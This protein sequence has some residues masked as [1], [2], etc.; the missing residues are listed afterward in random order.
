VT[1]P[2]FVLVASP[3]TGPFAW[4]KVA[5]EL[6]ARGR[7]VA[8]DGVDPGLDAPVVLV[9]HSGAGPRLPMVATRTDGVVGMV[10]VDS[11][12]PHPDQSWAETAPRALI[13]HLRA[14][15]RDGMLP[16]WPE[17]WPASAMRDILPDET[18]R[19]RF[20]VDCPSVPE[21]V[22]DEVMPDVPEPPAA[23]VQLS[24]VCAADANAAEA[25]GWP[26]IRVDGSHLSILTAPEEAVD[27]IVRAGDCLP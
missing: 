8:I 4:S 14:I 26:V 16:P 12:M 23:Y 7:R 17:W 22:L 20:V 13:E 10:L 6:G 15:A 3:F 19:E 27:A 5:H 1:A 11:P 21:T 18:M 2:G 25:R 9:G 24:A